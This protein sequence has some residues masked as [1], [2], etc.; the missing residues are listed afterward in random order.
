MKDAYFYV[1]IF[2]K[3]NTVTK[4]SATVEVFIEVIN[5]MFHSEYNLNII[6]LVE[7]VNFFY[8]FLL[9]NASH[10]TL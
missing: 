7:T 3:F 2:L 4:T 1:Q 8:L 6:I 5:S 10:N 9:S